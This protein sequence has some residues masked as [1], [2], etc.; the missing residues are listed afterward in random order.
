M[1]EFGKY[2]L[3]RKY[4]SSDGVNYTPLDEYQALLVENNSCQ[5]GYR[6]LEY[7]F[8]GEYNNDTFKKYEI[9]NEYSFCPTDSSYDELTGNVDYR[10]PIANEGVMLATYEGNGSNSVKLFN[11]YDFF[12]NM[13][14]NNVELDSKTSGYT[15]NNTDINEAAYS[16]VT[17]ISTSAFTQCYN[18]R[19]IV[20]PDSVTTI[21]GYS[22]YGCGLT[23]VT[24]PDSVTSIGGSAFGNCGY[25]TSVTIGSGVT[26]IGGSAFYQCST[27]TSVNIL[28]G[29]K[30]IG[31]SAFWNCDGLTSF[32]IPDSVTTIGDSAFDSCD[33]LTSVTIGN[34][35]NTIGSSAFTGCNRLTSVTIPDSVTSIGRMAFSNCSDLTSVTIGSGVTS[36]DSYTF[37]NCSGLTSVIIPSSVTLIGYYSFSNCKSLTSVTI[38]SSVTI[39]DDVAFSGCYFPRDKLINNSSVSGYPWGA[40]LYDVVQDDG[41]CINGTTADK[42]RPKATNVTIPYSV[43]KIGSSAFYECRSLTSVIIPD[44]VITIGSNAF[45]YCTSLTSVTIPSSVTNIYLYAFRNCSSLTSITCYATKAP[46]LGRDVFDYLPTNGTLHVPQGSYYSSWLTQLG[47]G[48]TIE[49]I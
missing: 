1:N 25:L 31:A 46:S 12:E 23:S 27:L 41:L 34:S 39:I 47:S 37:S 16:N 10:N 26:S 28:Y 5:C 35:V 38:P 20:I 6:E 18:L 15:F 4:V 24:I 2:R 3:F 17:S 19:T 29:V 48:W 49:Y 7:R 44:S 40:N 45:Q 36:I 30:T 42:C 13:A 22:F 43:T 21:G 11:N 14:I 9:W 33:Y 32:T 8:D